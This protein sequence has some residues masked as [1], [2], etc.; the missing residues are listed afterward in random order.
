M[1]AP[2]IEMYCMDGCIYCAR[3]KRLL[4]KK[5]M[6]WCERRVDKDPG[7]W[8]EITTRT[9]RNTVPQIF[10]DGKHVGGYDDMAELDMDGELDKLL[11]LPG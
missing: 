6:Q 2:D 9:G 1:A 5:G 11:G 10:I 3:A 8:K 4:E 7:L